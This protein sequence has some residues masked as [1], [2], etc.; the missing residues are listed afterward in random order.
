MKKKELGIKLFTIQ[1]TNHIATYSKM[2][3]CI[4]M[5]YY[6]TNFNENYKTPMELI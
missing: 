2:K 4:K 1:F 3:K 5:Y 6:W